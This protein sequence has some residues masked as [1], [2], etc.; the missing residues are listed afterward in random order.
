MC[1]CIYVLYA[2]AENKQCLYIL[3]TDRLHHAVCMCACMLICMQLNMRRSVVDL[4][5]RVVCWEHVLMCVHFR[6]T[7]S[8]NILSQSL[9][10]SRSL[11]FAI[12]NKSR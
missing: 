11:D 12:A 10:S 9:V 8:S 7:L 1:M 5:T 3:H 2:C 4:F 6:A